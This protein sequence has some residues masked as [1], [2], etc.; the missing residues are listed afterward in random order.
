MIFFLSEHESAFREVNMAQ[1]IILAGGYSSRIGVNKMTLPYRDQPLICHTVQS[2][3]KSVSHIFVVTGHYHEDIVT[4]LLPFSNLSI[5]HN[6]NYHQGMFTSV[7]AGIEFVTEDFFIIPGDYPLIK[8]TTYELLKTTHSE[9]AVPTFNGTKGHPLF[10]RA[11]LIE[12]LKLEPPISNLKTFRDHYP[13]AL[14]ETDDEGI[15]IDIDTE[16]DHMS[17]LGRD[18]GK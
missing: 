8:P 16:N 17:L 3:A 7:K 5:I 18:E 15:L 6:P 4:A 12:A 14:I 11:S 1:G 10:I 13:I 9:I 2:M